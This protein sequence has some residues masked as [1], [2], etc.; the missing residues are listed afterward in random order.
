MQINPTDLID[1]SFYLE[2]YEDIRTAGVDPATHFAEHGWKEGRMPNEFFFTTW[3]IQTYMN[4]K[5][6]FN[7]LE[8]YLLNE[9]CD[10][11]PL[12]CRSF[13]AELAESNIDPLL[14][15]LQN[16]NDIDYTAPWFSRRFYANTYPHYKNETKSVEQYFLNHGLPAGHFSAPD[17]RPLTKRRLKATGLW[18]TSAREIVWNGQIYF[19]HRSSIPSSVLSQI[20]EQGQFDS[21]IFGPGHKAIRNLPLY[22][23]DDIETRAGF[24]FKDLLDGISRFPEIVV[25]LPTLG[26]GGAEKYA[27]TL[28][29]ATNK[30]F[31]LR[32][33]LITTDAHDWDDFNALRSSERRTLRQTNVLTL[34]PILN[35]VGSPQTLLALYLLYLQPRWTIVVNS[36][37]AIKMICTHGLV[38]SQTMRIGVTFFS[39][40]PKGIG[41]PY[42][43][44]YLGQVLRSAEV[45][46]DNRKSLREYDQKT[47]S[48]FT[49]KFRYIPPTLEFLD[50]T[51]FSQ[52]VDIHI[53]RRSQRSR[54]VLWIGRWEKFKAIDVVKEIAKSIEIDIFAP[55][56]EWDDTMPK[57]LQYRGLMKNFRDIETSDYEAFIFTS[58][59]EGMPNTVLEMVD[60]A[61]PVVASCVGGLPE[62]FNHSEIS[63]VNMESES[64]SEIALAFSREINNI[65]ELPDQLLK[66]RLFAARHA[67]LS[68]HS[69]EIYIDNIRQIFGE[70][71]VSS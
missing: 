24:D 56:F 65:V 52:L 41:A 2:T 9:Q 58:Y 35:R 64:A 54:K 13:V 22:A 70:R 33:L 48:I 42:P 47:G 50:E 10:P 55:N 57:G 14:W 20:D 62:T 29:E 45:W 31:G 23:G 1:A 18:P 11:S 5:F 49:S 27:S 59:F 43:T 61:I 32:T 60:S 21:R 38:L 30:E 67:A 66:E 25:I 63:F 3:Y 12:F 34:R 40:A 36:D 71:S 4:S 69:H 15:A 6:E 37:V 19:H 51:T 46:S 17:L 7:P 68:K 28:I 53:S 39:E 44:R 26:T 16:K 8:H